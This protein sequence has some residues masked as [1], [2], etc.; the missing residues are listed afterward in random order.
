MTKD[1][2]DMA[3]NILYSSYCDQK[4]KDQNQQWLFPWASIF[5]VAKSVQ[6][7]SLLLLKTHIWAFYTGAQLSSR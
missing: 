7:V 5:F 1:F 3:V 4:Q 2:K 6:A